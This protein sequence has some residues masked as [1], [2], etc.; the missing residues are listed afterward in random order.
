MTRILIVEDYPSL[1]FLYQAALEAEGFEVLSATDG[2]KALKVAQ[3]HEPDLILLDLLMPN[4][5]GLEFLRAYNIK[6]HPSVKVVVFSNMASPELF[7]EAKQ[8]GA[9]QYLVKANYT[10]KEVVGAIKAALQA[11]TPPAPSKPP[12]R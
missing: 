8:L 3:E 9:L 7:D 1:Q 12:T 11:H 6:R 4:E 5:G 2:E 10:P